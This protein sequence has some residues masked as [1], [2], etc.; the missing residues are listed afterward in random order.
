MYDSAG[1]SKREPQL[2]SLWRLLKVILQGEEEGEK[3][4]T[5]WYIN[6]SLDGKLKWYV[7][8]VF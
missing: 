3:K 5:F 4:K 7:F 8:I 6:I 1:H 2:R